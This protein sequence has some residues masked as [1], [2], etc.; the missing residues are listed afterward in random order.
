MDRAVELWGQPRKVTSFP[1]HDT[2]V[3]DD[4]KD[5]TQAVLE[6]DKSMAVISTAAKMANSGC[7]G[8]DGPGRGFC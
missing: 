5:N 1:R 2:S 7:G 8:G 3:P 6:Y 4:L